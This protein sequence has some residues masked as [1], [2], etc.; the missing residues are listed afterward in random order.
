MEYELHTYKESSY[1]LIYALNVREIHYGIGRQ[2]ITALVDLMENMAEN[3]R[4]VR[5]DYYAC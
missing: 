3:E 2:Y 5:H 1:W 4:M